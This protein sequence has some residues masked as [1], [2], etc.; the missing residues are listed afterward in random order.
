MTGSLECQACG[1]PCVLMGMLGRRVHYRC[2]DC[3]MD[4]NRLLEEG[5]ILQL[6]D[7][8]EVLDVA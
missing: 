2:R 8:G 4:N 3:G 1:G 6:E 5:E 7:E